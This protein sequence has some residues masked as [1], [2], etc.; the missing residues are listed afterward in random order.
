MAS[1]NAFRRRDDE[2][3]IYRDGW[4]SIAF[5]TYRVNAS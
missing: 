1:L 5:T 3:Q 4:N 2:V